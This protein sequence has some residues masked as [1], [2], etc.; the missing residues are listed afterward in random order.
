MKV[1]EYIIR[2]LDKTADGN[3]SARS[4]ASKTAGSILSQMANI[5]AAWD[6]GSGAIVS[7]AK[8]VWSAVKEAFKFE[9]LTIQFSVLMGSLTKAKD[10]MKELADFAAAT[11]FAMEEVVNASRQLHVFSDGALGASNSLRL[12]GDAAAAVG[13]NIQEVSFWVGRAY[14]MIKG[15][16]P[17]GEAAMRLQE[18]GIITPDRKSVV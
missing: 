8:A 9:T 12:V 15:G 7:G 16:Q 1:L 11:P 14:S 13:Q 3:K 5:K 10:R 2:A 4:E 18:M 6:M 17:F